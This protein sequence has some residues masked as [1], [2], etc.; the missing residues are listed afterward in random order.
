M[1]ELGLGAISA[2]GKLLSQHEDLGLVS[3]TFGLKMKS[4]VVQ[5]YSYRLGEEKTGVS[6]GFTGQPYL[7]GRFPVE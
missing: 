3:N 4:T 1:L 5:D 7:L 2:T 6:P